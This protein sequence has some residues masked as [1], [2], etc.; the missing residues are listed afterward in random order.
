MNPKRQRLFQRPARS[1]RKLKTDRFNY[2]RK[3]EVGEYCRVRIRVIDGG[4]RDPNN[5]QETVY[6]KLRTFG[7]DFEPDT[8]QLINKVADKIEVNATRITTNF[9]GD[10]RVDAGEFVTVSI[11]IVGLPN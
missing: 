9:L 6:I 7:S 2:A 4:S 3:I 11:D 10:R 1:L 8:E 5:D